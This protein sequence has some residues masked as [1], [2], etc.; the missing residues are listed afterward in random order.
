MDDYIYSII[1]NTDRDQLSIII[2]DILKPSEYEK[3]KHAE[4]STPYSL[5]QEMLNTIPIEFWKSP[6]KVFE[7][8]SGKGG[9]LL[10][11]VN[12]FMDNLDI[13]D[14]DERYR[15]IVEE[16]LYFSD[17]STYNIHV[18]K[19]LLDI[20]GVY[21]LNY[22]EGN[23]LELDIKNKWGLLS[24]GRYLDYDGG[25]P[26]RCYIIEYGCPRLFRTKKL[27]LRHCFSGEEPVKVT[28]AVVK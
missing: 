19:L 8:C 14:E 28:I 12:K 26:E 3:N 17:I 11:I 24:L 21:H 6:K 20:D 16:C 7:P 13:Q 2:D 4:V 9:F 25:V 5:R 27:A 22:N 18:N 15:I 23:T 10:D 1:K